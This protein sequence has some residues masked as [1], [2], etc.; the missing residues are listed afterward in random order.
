MAENEQKALVPAYV[1]YKSFTNFIN[2]LRE[3]GVPGRLDRS[4]MRGLSGSAQSAIQKSFEFLKLTDLDGKPTP[5]MR[6]LVAAEGEDRKALMKQMLQG[7]YDFV[8]DEPNFL[9]EATGHM[10][11]DKFRAQGVS[12][13]TVTKTVAF[14]LAAA[15]DA[16]VKVSPHVRPPQPP[17]NTVKRAG[18]KK[19][20]EDDFDLSDDQDDELE[21]D[22]DTDEMTRF[23]IP[24]PGKKSATVIIPKNLTAQDWD[25]LTLML[26]AYVKRLQEQ[27]PSKDLV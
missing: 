27:Q 25:M 11:A 12:G 22:M 19:G 18:K 17:R 7:A 8:F 3:N 23:Q 1:P 10:V 15:K 2:G 14:F 4:V 6:K 21:N 20:R 5:L 13:S 16:D 9:E 24:I 26:N